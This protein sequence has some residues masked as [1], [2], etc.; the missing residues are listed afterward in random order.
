MMRQLVTERL[1]LRAWQES[2]APSLFKYASDPELG[3][4][5]GWA[6]H[7]SEQ[8]SLQTI[9]TIFSMEG[10]WAVELKETSEVIGCVGYLPSEA[11]NLEIADNECEVGYW[12]ARPYWNQ[13]F[14]TEAL[15]AVM[16]YCVNVQRF[17]VLW[18]C[19]FPANPAS[20]KVMTKC[21][22]MDTGEEKLCP[23]LD[24]GAD[25]PVR[26]LKYVQ[27]STNNLP[28]NLQN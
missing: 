24:V 7:Q 17:A 2:D 22:F 14:G 5:A 8:E 19:Y 6:P 10:M 3:P 23:T 16:D 9:R 4:R 28:S 13:G 21:S 12:V 11:S 18:G 15:Q 25:K 26:I 1:I 20:G 27:I